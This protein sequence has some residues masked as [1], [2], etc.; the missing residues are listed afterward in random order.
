M[1]HK[2][3][4]TSAQVGSDPPF[5]HRT[6]V[7]VTHEREGCCGQQHEGGRTHP[8]DPRHDPFHEL[9]TTVMLLWEKV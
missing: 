2:E 7:R 1:T 6:N 3:C 4:R 8:L 9:N 5:L